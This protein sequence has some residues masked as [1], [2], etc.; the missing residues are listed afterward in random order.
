MIRDNNPD[1][2]SEINEKLSSILL[3]LDQLGDQ[4]VGLDDR[5]HEVLARWTHYREDLTGDHDEM[6]RGIAEELNSFVSQKLLRLA[7]MR[8]R[9][10]ASGL[11]RRQTAQLVSSLCVAYL[12]P[13]EIDLIRVRRM[14]KAR[15]GD[16]CWQAAGQA[17]LQAK[18][19]LAAAR[20]R[21]AEFSWDYDCDEGFP[22]DGEI[23]QVW[24]NCDPVS[25]VSFVVVPG[26]VADGERYLLQQVFTETV[27]VGAEA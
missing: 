16:E 19:I 13:A 3:R 22:L 24:S 12:G 5:F 1:V 14:L 4:V 11:T 8:S 23:Q 10:T 2:L 9:A 17:A 27:E 21:G 20:A 15:K 18:K 6:H 7:Y 25:D 26:Y